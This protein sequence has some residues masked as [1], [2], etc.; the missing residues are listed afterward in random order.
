MF[1]VRT[2]RI[3]AVGVCVA[4]VSGG[5]GGGGGGGRGARRPSIC[6]E[7]WRASRCSLQGV[8]VE[9]KMNCGAMFRIFSVQ[10][11]NFSVSSTVESTLR[12]FMGTAGVQQVLFEDP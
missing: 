6:C 5:G 7:S 2:G 3:F 12:V 10:S 8:W 1:D 9:N 4:S 11:S